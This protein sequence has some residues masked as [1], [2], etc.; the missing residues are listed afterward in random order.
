LFPSSYRAQGDG[1]VRSSDSFQDPSVST[2]AWVS[3]RLVQKN[4]L[5]PPKHLLLRHPT[6]LKMGTPAD[7]LPQPVPDDD[8]NRLLVTLGLP[9][10]DCIQRATV[11][12]EY[13]GVYLIT[14]PPNNLAEHSELLL[15]VS[16]HHLPCIKTEN[17]VGV[18]SWVARN[19]SIPLPALVAYDS[20]TANPTGHEYTL[21]ERVSGETLFD[22][23]SS[24][25]DTEIVDDTFW[26][27]PEIEKLWPENETVDSLNLGGPY[28]TN[29]DLV[30]AKSRPI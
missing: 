12:A 30:S 28:R 14:M 11:T 10:A 29:A 9:P 26:M 27:P 5:P 15:R 16:G 6:P 21:L 4:R 1:L 8:I 17:G 22:I 20:T 3:I 18:I 19:T 23:Y 25:N 2:E 13:H 7:Y 24:L